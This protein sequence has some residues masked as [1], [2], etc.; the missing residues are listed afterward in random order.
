MGRN[1]RLMAARD[2]LKKK[3]CFTP[4]SVEG[5]DTGGEALTLRALTVD[6]QTEIA[7]SRPVPLEVTEENRA[8]AREAYSL[9]IFSL[10]LGDSAGNRVYE[11]EEDFAE[12]KKNI[13][14]LVILRVVKEGMAYNADETKKN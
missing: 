5:W 4:F 2:K 13:P 3:Q 12:I 1:L 8:Q 7:A 11:S 14:A 10:L 9:K 6:E